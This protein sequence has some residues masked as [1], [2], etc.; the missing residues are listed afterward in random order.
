M[1]QV[2][3]TTKIRK[4]THLNSEQRKTIEHLLR[5]GA[6]KAEIAWTLKRDKSTIKRE[7]KRGSVIQRRENPY[8]SRNKNVPDYIDEMVYFWDVGQRVYEKNRQNC[9]A[10]NKV[11]ACSAMVEF[12]EEMILGEEKWSPDTAI[13]HAKV[14]KSLPGTR[15]LHKDVL[16]LDR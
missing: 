4:S 10:K 16:Q 14:H 9:G 7:I 5:K 8:A 6:N 3:N 13:G 15:I 1:S 11:V 12:V 2:D